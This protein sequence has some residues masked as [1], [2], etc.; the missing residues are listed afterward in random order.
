MGSLYLYDEDF[1]LANIS[2]DKRD[3]VVL[4]FFEMK[5]KAAQDTFCATYELLYEKQFSYGKGFHSL[6]AMNWSEMCANPSCAG[7]K[8]TTWTYLQYE[9]WNKPTICQVESYESISEPKTYA[10][11][12]EDGDDVCF[13]SDYLTWKVWHAQWYQTH[14]TQIHWEDGRC[15]DLLPFVEFATDIL[16]SELLKLRAHY[17]KEQERLHDE[18]RCVREI[19]EIDGFL[20]KEQMEHFTIADG[21]HSL[22]MA[23]KGSERYAYAETIGK[24]VLEIN[25]YIFEDELTQREQEVAKSLRSVFS[26]IG[27]DGHKQY[28]SIDFEHGMFEFINH[29]NVHLGEFRFDGT[30]NSGSEQDHAF[31][32]LR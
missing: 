4:K 18:E 26:I 25:G 12:K 28:V 22:I 14:Q 24:Q 7:I 10:K 9:Y 30:Y 13:V 21:F 3:E 31:K 19:R 1:E 15:N 32:T 6:Y 20:S 17:V 8:Q 11:F 23:H 16:K 27:K 29:L 2:A 5:S